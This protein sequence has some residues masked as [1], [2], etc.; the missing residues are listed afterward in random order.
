MIVGSDLFFRPA[1]IFFIPHNRKLATISNV[2]LTVLNSPPRVYGTLSSDS[3]TSNQTG[4]GANVT[5]LLNNLLKQYDNSLRPE[6]GGNHEIKSS[7]P[8]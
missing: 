6:L 2:T 7:K 3:T 1:Y 5:Y 4:G 8:L